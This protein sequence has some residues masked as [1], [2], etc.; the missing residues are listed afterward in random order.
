MTLAVS[1]SNMV[2]GYITVC[3]VK[4]NEF[5]KFWLK[6]S[7]KKDLNFDCIFQIWQI[8][9]LTILCLVILVSQS[10]GFGYLL[11]PVI[12]TLRDNTVCSL[13][14][15][16]YTS[17][18]VQVHWDICTWKSKTRG[19]LKVKNKY[20]CLFLLKEKEE[21]TNGFGSFSFP[22]KTLPTVFG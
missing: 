11:S 8:N 4:K 1:C 7:K 2:H 6:P 17:V 3:G 22:H 15:L 5:W 16:S 20:L 13:W 12:F 18:Y 10:L 21:I 9:T 14:K 19:N